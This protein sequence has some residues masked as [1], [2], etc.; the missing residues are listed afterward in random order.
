[1]KSP[2]IPFITA[3]SSA[4][5]ANTLNVI[6]ASHSLIQLNVQRAANFNTE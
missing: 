5:R 6:L 2:N 4:R 3:V 1:M